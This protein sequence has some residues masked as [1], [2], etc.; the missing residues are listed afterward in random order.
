MTND[1]DLT[2]GTMAPPWWSNQFI[3]DVAIQRWDMDDAYTDNDDT[4]DGHN[5]DTD[6]DNDDETIWR[7]RWYWWW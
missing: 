7:W 5:D 3:L 6:D 4:D 2:D 1:F